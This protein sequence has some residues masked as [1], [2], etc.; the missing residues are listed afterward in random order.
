MPGF[1]VFRCYDKSRVVEVTSQ[2][3]P[4]GSFHIDLL[5]IEIGVPVLHTPSALSRDFT[6]PFDPEH[7]PCPILYSMAS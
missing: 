7:F 5:N 4:V 2:S 1:V 3:C 6:S